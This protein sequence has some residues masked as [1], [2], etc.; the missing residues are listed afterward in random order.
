MKVR[1]RLATAASL[2][3]MSATAHAA[4]GVVIGHHT[5]S[6]EDG[7]PVIGPGERTKVFF[8]TGSGDGRMAMGCALDKCLAHYNREKNPSQ[9][10]KGK[11]EK[12]TALFGGVCATEGW[13]ERNGH[14]LMM[15]GPPGDNVHLTSKAL[16]AATREEARRIVCSNGF[17]CDRASIAFEFY[18]GSGHEPRKAPPKP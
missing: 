6:D 15:V 1:K 14:N 16:S 18:D 9:E 4:V 2:L 17:P 13:T 8:C 5:W 3:L 12:K 7:L 11:G 10:L